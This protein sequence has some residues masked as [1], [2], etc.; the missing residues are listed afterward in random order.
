MPAIV[1]KDVP[2]ELHRWLKDEAERNR[3]SMAQQMLLILEQAK[4][5]PLLPISAPP[6]IKTLKPFTQTFLRKAI[7]EGRP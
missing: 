2:R 4:S 5:R 7:E 6:R 3:R 1:L